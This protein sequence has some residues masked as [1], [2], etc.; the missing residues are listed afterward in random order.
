MGDLYDFDGSI[1]ITP[2]LNF[3]EIRTVRAALHTYLVDKIY[4]GKVPRYVPADLESFNIEDHFDLTPRVEEQEIDTD[5][6]TL[7]MKQARVIV[8]T[9]SEGG[10]HRSTLGGQM[11]VIVK[12]LPR[13]S[14]KGTATM[15]HESGSSGTKLVVDGRKVSEY[16]GTGYIKFEDGSEQEIIY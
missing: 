3:K 4:G 5:E 10:G 13:H 1:E 2:P 12:A 16:K 8:P 9:R 6:G 14:F 11:E 15:I 7:T